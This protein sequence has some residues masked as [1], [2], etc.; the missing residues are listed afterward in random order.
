MAVIFSGERVA[1]CFVASTM[2]TRTVRRQQ[3]ALSLV[4]SEP[5]ANWRA[6]HSVQVT[7]EDSLSFAG[8][9]PARRRAVRGP[10]RSF[11]SRRKGDGSVP[12]TRMSPETILDWQWGEPS[13]AEKE[14]S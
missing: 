8:A 1:A 7:P 13:N 6:G 12:R 4:R 10:L 9:H 11:T 2:Q 14:T 3:K 5:I